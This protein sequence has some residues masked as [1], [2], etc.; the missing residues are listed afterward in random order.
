MKKLSLRL[1][2]GFLVLSLGVFFIGNLLV[3]AQQKVEITWMFW[4]S[5]EITKRIL[6]PIRDDFE[7]EYPGIKVKMTF[8]AGGQYFDKLLTM[9]AGGTPPDVFGFHETVALDYPPRG[10]VLNLQPLIER[11]NFDLGKYYKLALDPFRY[12]GDLY[13]LP[14]DGTITEV[15]TFYNVDLFDKAGVSYPDETWTWD[16]FLD[17]AKKLTKKVKGRTTQWGFCTD[18]GLPW[19]INFVWQ[20]EGSIFNKEGTRCTLDEPAAYEALQWY[21]DLANK[22]QV[23]PTPN[24]SADMGGMMQMF[25][26]G[27]VAMINGAIWMVPIF[28]DIKDFQWDVAVPPKGKVRAVLVCGSAF[29]I[30][31]ESKYIDESW[32]FLKFATGETG[33]IYELKT[34]SNIPAIKSLADSELFLDPT[35]P[36]K[37]A[38][39]CLDVLEYGRN[40]DM[41]PN[42]SRVIQPINTQLDYLWT[43][44]KTAKEVCIEAAKQANKLLAEITK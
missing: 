35:K 18:K 8:V 19:W 25:L 4:G 13:G 39:I 9:I 17:A 20:N 42:Y 30:S 21:A 14:W 40:Y 36:P 2:V 23:S 5:P 3:F 12:K 27:K 6:T 26:T 7:K 43:G 37:N 33:C 24:Y 29:A 34:G 16:T 10:M 32:E 41:C 22:Y 1:I 31:P 15:T 28:R 11:D 44:E 38:R